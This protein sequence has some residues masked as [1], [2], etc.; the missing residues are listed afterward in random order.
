[1]RSWL[2]GVAVLAV[3]CSSSP[4]GTSDDGNDG[5]VEG[6]IPPGDSGASG[7]SGARPDS[8]SGPDATSSNDATAAGDA[9]SGGGDGESPADATMEDGSFDVTVPPADAGADVGPASPC[10][11]RVTY[12]AAWIPPANHPTNFDVLSGLV[13]WDGTCTNDGANSYATLSNGFTPHFTGNSA[14]ILALDADAAACPSVPGQCA[15]RITYGSAWIPASNHPASYDDVT[16]RVFSDGVCTANGSSSSAK[17]SNGWV[18]SFNGAAGCGLSFRYTQCGGLYTNPV[19]PTDCPD[20]GVL[21]D[22]NRYVLTCTSGNAADA[23]PLYTSPDLATWTPAGHVFPSA[24][25]PTWAMSDFWAPEIHVVGGQYV[26]Y[27]SA[28]GADGKLAIGAASASSALGPY[29]AQ[30]QPLVHDASMGL[31]DAS[32]FEGGG[33]PYVL[34]KEDGNAVGKPTPIHAQPLTSDGLSLSGSASTLITNDQGWEGAVVEGPFMVQDNGTYYLFYSGNSYASAAYAIGVARASSPT[35]PFTKAAA[36]I[37]V[38]NAAWAGPGH[39][40]VVVATPSSDSAI[41]YHAW[42]SNCINGP[43]CARKTLVDEVVW[44]GG[45]PS[46]VLAPSSTTRPLW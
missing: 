22:G 8:G 36:P 25:K 9:T 12:G 45:W 27:F 29:T 40:S 31:I 21:Q 13:T 4:G 41:I 23:F 46:V 33:T 11:T 30:A 20:P 24:S 38:S 39:C 35:G 16:G 10:T 26:A 18:P 6:S 1:M 37:L 15:T 5:S 17:L 42:P 34:W 7:D 44:T 19:I 32:E 28:R 14:C 43:G 3:G 2:I